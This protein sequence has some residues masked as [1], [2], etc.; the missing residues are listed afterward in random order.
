ME[1]LINNF[2]NKHICF[3]NLL[4]V[5]GAKEQILKGGV[6]KKK[7]GTTGLYPIRKYWLNLCLAWL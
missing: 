4:K 1:S 7:F 2:T 5:K 3:Y 6:V